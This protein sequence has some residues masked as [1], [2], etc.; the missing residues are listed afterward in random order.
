MFAEIV[1][2]TAAKNMENQPV[3][4]SILC[5]VSIGERLDE[6]RR[7]KGISQKELAA[8]LGMKPQTLNKILKGRVRSPG[9]VVIASI[10]ARLEADID[11][12]IRRDQEIEEKKRNQNRLS[13]TASPTRIAD[14]PM[15]TGKLMPFEIPPEEFE[16]GDYDYPQTY[17]GG[18]T[19][20]TGGA[21]AGAFDEVDVTGEVAEV[22]NPTLRDIQSGRY[23]VVKV[24]GDSMYPRLHDGDLVLVDTF[25]KEP[26]P[27]RIMAVYRRRSGTDKG[28]STFGYVHRVG[29]ALILTKANAGKYPPV[30][31]TEREIIQ[32]TVKKRLAENLE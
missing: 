26:R 14:A 17:R 27:N 5:A 4:G 32:G 30:I 13:F 15:Q 3:S 22:L 11:D 24:R 16:E 10:V 23:G 7:A 18:P 20:V 9:F 8:D 21:T 25:D 29:D 1:S 12:L 19:E 6:V 31:L 28:G 2:N